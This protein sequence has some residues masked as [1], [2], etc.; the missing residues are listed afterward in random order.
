MK[1]LLSTILIFTFSSLFAT[2]NSQHVS[3]MTYN[4]R[5]DNPG[6]VENRWDNRKDHAA[7]LLRFYEPGIIGTQE[8]LK[9]Q[10]DYLNNHLE[11]YTYVGVAREDGAREGEYSAIFIDTTRF[12]ID[13]E[14]TFWLSETPEIPSTGWDANIKRVCTFALLENRES[15]NKFYVFNA[16]LDHRGEKSRM[17]SVKLIWKKVEERTGSSKYP[18]IVMGDLNAEPGDDPI[19]FLNQHLNDAYKISE[20]PPYGPVGTFNSFDVEKPAERRIDYIFVSD[21][22]SVKKYAS[23][24]DSKNS[25][26]PSDH[27]PVYAELD[28]E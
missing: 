14:Q 2:M 9:H 12:K 26:Y 4:L 25:R 27:F 22:F 6:D 24:S 15:G 8:A 16:H 19:A 21:E 28:L 7:G 3:A 10:L 1:I 17:Q 11:E 18:V 23:I 5:F 20:E 13:K